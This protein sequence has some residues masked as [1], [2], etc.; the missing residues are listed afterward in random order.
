MTRKR[1]VLFLPHRDNPG[2]GIRTSA[3]LVPLELLQI[4]TYPAANGYEVVMI[5]AMVHEDYEKRVLEACE[6]ALVFATSCILGYQVYHGATVA[7][8]VRAKFPKLPILWGGWF[9]SVY[10]EL[11]LQNDVADAVGLGQ[12]EMTFWECV[13]AL[14]SGTPLDDVP[15]LAL[16]RDGKLH[17]TAHRP[18]VGFDEI[19]RVPWELLDYELYVK[20]QNTK[21]PN[22]VRQTH[23]TPPGLENKPR[24]AITYYSSYGCPEPCTFCCSPIVTGRRW[25]AIPGKVLAE[26]VLELHDRFKF[27]TLRYQDANFGVAEKRSNEWCEAL[28]A[29][30][31]PFFWSATYEIET[32]AR[33]KESSCDL[34]KDSRCYLL[35][36]GAEAGT[37]EQQVRIKK[38]IDVNKSLDLCFGRATERGMLT[39]ATWIIGY[40]RESRESMLGTLLMAGKIK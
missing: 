7:R 34:L 24:R 20:L 17:K 28:I 37:Q 5:D 22:K 35:I 32:V 30:K 33:Y 8:A 39:H 15:G 11:F 18:V 13:Q 36:T 40:P 23:P 25:K 6:G 26:R 21:S 3:D 29:A 1:I 12:G 2:L 19:P 9:P 14:D 38:N 10:P 4:A 27:D 16:W 31:T